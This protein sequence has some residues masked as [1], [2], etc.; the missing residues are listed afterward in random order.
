MRARVESD[1]VSSFLDAAELIA[2]GSSP[3]VFDNSTNLTTV[4]DRLWG[5]VPNTFRFLESDS[6]LTQMDLELPVNCA[7]SE[8]VQVEQQWNANVDL[9]PQDP[10]LNIS[11][12]EDLF[13]VALVPNC[14]FDSLRRDSIFGGNRER[15]SVH[16]TANVISPDFADQVFLTK[17]ANR[18]QNF[19]LSPEQKRLARDRQDWRGGRDVSSA[20]DGVVIGSL[21]IRFGAVVLATGPEDLPDYVS[22]DWIRHNYYGLMGE[23]LGDCPPRP[24]GFPST[25]SACFAFMQVNCPTFEE[26]FQWLP[27]IDTLLQDSDCRLREVTMIW[28]KG[29]EADAEMV[30]VLAGIYGRVQPDAGDPSASREFDFNAI[31]A[32][33]FAIGSLGTR[34]TLVETVSPRINAVYIG[35]M[36]LP[37]FLVL[38]L[39]S[40]AVAARRARLAIPQTP[41]ELMVFARGEK[42]IPQRDVQGQFPELTK[43]E[44]NKL[45]LI[46]DETGKL[47]IAN[48]D[49]GLPVLPSATLG[50]HDTRSGDEGTE[51][52]SFH[53][54][55]AEKVSSP[56]KVSVDP[57]GI[58]SHGYNKAS[59]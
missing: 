37:F 58:W 54:A 42:Q 32:A 40:V 30:A 50:D 12:Q 33:M 48:D 17:E 1:L 36:L 22:F 53:N 56:Q 2:R 8:M 47:T 9:I 13:P 59:V 55:D 43:K 28:G 7:Q 46:Q 15:A 19:Q 3:F 35:F 10:T 4:I 25:E 14:T 5:G 38:I 23:V 20:I 31:F 52:R 27:Q 29:F 45:K 16:E 6:A 49:F 51:S 44:S 57:S 11:N 26:D 39:L 41:W 24:S 18:F 34:P 21:D